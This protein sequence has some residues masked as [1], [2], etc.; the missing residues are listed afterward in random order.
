MKEKN[1]IGRFFL[2]NLRDAANRIV[3][4][5][6]PHDI[7]DILFF[8]S[9]V[10]FLLLCTLALALGEK[11]GDV[12]YFTAYLVSLA[13]ALG[14]GFLLYCVVTHLPR[15]G[16]AWKAVTNVI[17][18]I[19]L[20]NTLRIPL[21]QTIHMIDY[22]FGSKSYGSS[23]SSEEVWISAMISNRRF[24]GPAKD[25]FEYSE[26]LNEEAYG[27][28]PY[29]VQIAH[30]KRSDSPYA[31]LCF[32]DVRLLTMLAYVYGSWIILIFAV[33][34]VI[35]CITAIRIYLK[36]YSRWFEW[37]YLIC[38]LAAANQVLTPVLFA[39]ELIPTQSFLYDSF[40][41]YGV[42]YIAYDFI[43]PLA[44]MLA[45]TKWNNDIV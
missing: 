32:Q 43:V 8:V 28:L 5:C 41:S 11:F 44:T 2:W 17:L 26:E 6:Y 31:Q 12:T 16:R 45:I 19:I 21:M 23:Q 9:S 24:W 40:Y 25:N 20:L 36:L 14:I 27:N 13:I 30:M 34:S 15:Y 22:L 33:V 39:L 37:V 35:W 42:K 18:A 10:V 38:F 4:F 1:T 29:E 7:G 3:K